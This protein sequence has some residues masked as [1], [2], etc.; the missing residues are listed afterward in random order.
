M[1]LHQSFK[2]DTEK[3]ETL[4]SRQRPPCCITIP[5]RLKLPFRRWVGRYETQEV[6]KCTFVRELKLGRFMRARVTEAANNC[7]GEEGRGEL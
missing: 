3:L 5:S 7:G 4:Q 2:Q 1:S 6:K